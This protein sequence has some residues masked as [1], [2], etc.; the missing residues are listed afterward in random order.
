M[1]L[2]SPYYYY[3]TIMTLKTLLW[4]RGWC[5]LQYIFAGVKQEFRVIRTLLLDLVSPEDTLKQVSQTRVV[6]PS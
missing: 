3:D 4:K 2:L 6:G 1:V 5:L